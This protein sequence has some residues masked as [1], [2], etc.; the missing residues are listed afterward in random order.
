MSS[1]I[2]YLLLHAM[3]LIYMTVKEYFRTEIAHSYIFQVVRL[4]DFDWLLASTTEHSKHRKLCHIVAR[5]LLSKTKT[6][7]KVLCKT[8]TF[9]RM[10]KSY[11]EPIISVNPLSELGSQEELNKPVGLSVNLNIFFF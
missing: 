8:K 6:K 9:V 2:P 3:H 1:V 10:E 7:K 5:I 4:C 11:S